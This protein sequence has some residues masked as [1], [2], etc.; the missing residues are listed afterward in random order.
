MHTEQLQKNKTHLN[1]E[2]L[3]LIGLIK[4]DLNSTITDIKTLTLQNQ[5]KR[6]V[7]SFYREGLLGSFKRINNALFF[8][9]K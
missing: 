5:F 8:Y 9:K 2:S 1:I 4:A 3:K 7:L 6:V